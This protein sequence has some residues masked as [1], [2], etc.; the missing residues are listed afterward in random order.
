MT[1]SGVAS[2]LSRMELGSPAWTVLIVIMAAKLVIVTNV[3]G[4]LGLRPVTESAIY[5]GLSV[6]VDSPL[7]IDASE[8]EPMAP[9]HLAERK[10]ALAYRSTLLTLLSLFAIAYLTATGA[11]TQWYT[12]TIVIVITSFARNASKAESMCMPTYQVFAWGARTACAVAINNACSSLTFVLARAF[13]PRAEHPSFVAF[14][15]SI[16]IG[17]H[18]CRAAV[19]RVLRMRQDTAFATRYLTTVIDLQVTTAF[20]VHERYEA[21]WAGTMSGCFVDAACVLIRQPAV[22]PST[23]CIFWTHLLAW[24]TAMPVQLA[25]SAGTKGAGQRFIIALAGQATSII[26]Q[27][28]IDVIQKRPQRD[29]YH[30]TPAYSAGDITNWV[31]YTSA[32]V[33]SLVSTAKLSGELL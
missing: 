4:Q 12:A 11:W 32:S 9:S 23:D 1:L 16:H 33:F 20:Y 19:A 27:G 2:Q 8:A 31:S 3:I 7:P 25:A 15:I 18:I 21:L 14:A 17:R 5:S 13:S 22:Q 29:K 30:R 10:R 6:L 26:L 24:I 28:L